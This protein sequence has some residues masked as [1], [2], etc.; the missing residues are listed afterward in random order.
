M[1]G[2]AVL[3]AATISTLSLC[4]IKTDPAVTI[5][6]LSSVVLVTW[7]SDSSFFWMAAFGFWSSALA[8][9][10]VATMATST[11][12]TP[13]DIAI[14]LMKV[15]PRLCIQKRSAWS[16]RFGENRDLLYTCL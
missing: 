13:F 8:A 3:V 9:E 12:S 2:L 15:P 4:R 11:A 6:D 1:Q 7:Y 16:M 10:G 5:S 14:V